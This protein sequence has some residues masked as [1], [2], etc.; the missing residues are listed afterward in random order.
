MPLDPVAPQ[1]FTPEESAQ[2]EARKRA[3]MELFVS[4]EAVLVIGAGCSVRL[5]YPSWPALLEKLTAL[6]S[7]IAADRSAAFNPDATQA[8]DYPLQYAGSI[9]TFIETC[10]GRLDKYY[11]LLSGEFKQR[12]VDSF[13]QQLVQIPARGILTTNYD[14]SL[15][16]ALEM[17]D[18]STTTADRFLIIEDDSARLVSEFLASLNR[19]SG[20]PRRIAHLHGR[21]NQPK[22]IILTDADYVD[23][24]RSRLNGA[25]RTAIHDVFRDGASSQQQAL[26]IAGLIEQLESAVPPWSLHRKLLWSILA[27]RRVVFIGFSLSDPYLAQMLALVADDLWRWKEVHH[28]AIMAL[29]DVDTTETKLQA[30]QFQRKYAVGVV[31]Y[32]N[33]APQHHQG[34]TSLVEEIANACGVAAEPTLQVQPVA[35]GAPAAAPA[36]QP[37]WIN[38]NNRIMKQRATK[39]AD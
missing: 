32:E 2:N 38:R 31:F 25:Q 8:R 19:G 5:Q 39:D 15:D 36:P 6:A 1:L 34:L 14:P 24:Y 20:I 9:K 16:V 27:T 11:G 3:M 17:T 28:F 35:P 33:R 7:E 21:Y 10:D 30:E 13:H 26:S 22:G 23:K 18:R 4:E 37:E 29:P 12:D